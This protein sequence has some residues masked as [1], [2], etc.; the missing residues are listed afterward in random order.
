[1]YEAKLVQFGIPA[2][3]LGFQLLQ[4]AASTMPAGLVSS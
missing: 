1:V 4:T 2:E 3:E